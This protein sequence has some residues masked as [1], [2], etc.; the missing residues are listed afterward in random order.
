MNQPCLAWVLGSMAIGNVLD[1]IPLDKGINEA[2]VGNWIL[3]VNNSKF[4]L[5]NP[6]QPTAEELPAF[7]LYCEN[8]EYLS[9]GMFGPRG[10]M[11]GG[12]TEDK[13]IAD[14]IPFLSRETL[15]DFS[16]ELDAFKEYHAKKKE[17]MQ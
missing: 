7:E 10:G 13:F 2:R 14:L 9:F 1:K 6:R 17:F 15:N 8:T 4:A 11:I 5:A 3:V 16:E 12:Y